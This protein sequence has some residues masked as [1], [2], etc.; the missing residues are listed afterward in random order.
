MAIDKED[1]AFR[2][3]YQKS[4]ISLSIHYDLLR[5]V[6]ISLLYSTNPSQRIGNGTVFSKVDMLH[7]VKMTFGEG[8]FRFNR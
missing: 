6:Y 4:K 5:I 2:D 3:D 7:F 8:E 1:E